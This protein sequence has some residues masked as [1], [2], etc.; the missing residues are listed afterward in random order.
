V[1][2]HTFLR[3]IL[4]PGLVQLAHLGGPKPADDIRQFLLTVALQESGPDLDARYQNSPS[5]SAG[6]ARSW[7]QFEESGGVAGVL[8]HASSGDL[9]RNACKAC[10]VQ[11]S[12]SAIWRAMEGHDRLATM[13]A[14]LL[15][16]TDPHAVPT[17]PDDAWDCYCNRLWRPGKPHPETWPGNWA[18]ATEAVAAVPCP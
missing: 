11:P 5:T 14:R 16:L 17:D 4:D 18:V 3:T 13:F 2:P 7:W 1:S 12:Q 6:P 15:V 10:H 9:A 8:G